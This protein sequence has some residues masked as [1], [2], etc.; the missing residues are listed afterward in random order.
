MNT[1]SLELIAPT[2]TS[3]PAPSVT[4]TAAPIAAQRDLVNLCS[5]ICL[6]SILSAMSP[7]AGYSA[8]IVALDNACPFPHDAGANEFDQRIGIGGS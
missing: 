4:A 3:P 7:A 5:I 1:R 6:R 8:E 2:L